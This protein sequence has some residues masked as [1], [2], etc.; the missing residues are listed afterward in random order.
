MITAKAP[1]SEA[2]EAPEVSEPPPRPNV[3]PAK[4]VGKTLPQSA[5]ELRAARRRILR[6]RYGIWV[7]LPTLLATIYYLFI[8]T[9]QY[10]AWVLMAVE[11]SEGRV[12]DAAGKAPN[13][14]NSRDARLLREALR[15]APALTRIRG[16]RAHYAEHGDWFNHLAGDAGNDTTLAYFRDKIRVT[17]E[18]G[19]NL[20][21][22]RV[23]AFSGE[24]AY[25][26]A[27]ELATFA[28]T[29]VEKQNES[30][31]TARLKQS[32][33][34]VTRARERLA[35]AA[36]AL[37]KV[38]Q[39][40]STDAVAIEHEVTEKRLE[41]S[42]KVLLEAQL[43]VGRAQRYL[44]V[45]DGPT[46]ADSVAAPRRVWGIMTVC[47]GALVL[48]SVLSLLGASVREHAKF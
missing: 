24:A 32:Q 13:A 14:G 12:N 8:A 20:T 31:S 48:V 36:A 28:Q 18:A 16:F 37:A 4:P 25:E 3:E 33:A 38:D 29:W 22:I 10:D 17:H 30:S 5:V 39:P 45:L 46:H 15:G 47:I 11:S 42:L 41:A 44:V 2:P 26:F 6:R 40:K 35:V 23:R 9:P 27:T 19:T 7:G 34:E 21:T 43:E 1:A